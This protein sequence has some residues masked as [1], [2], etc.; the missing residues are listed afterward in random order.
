MGSADGNSDAM[1]V[2]I[3][4]LDAFWIDKFEVTNALYKKCVDALKCYAPAYVVST[5]RSSYY[6]DAH[7]DNYPVIFVSWNEAN[8]F[9]AW[10]DKRLPTEAEWEKIARGTD[11]RIY[12]WGNSFN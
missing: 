6:G 10:A 11:E 7:Y 2:H 1:P 9:C 8:A 4:Y 12:Q 3:V 5:T